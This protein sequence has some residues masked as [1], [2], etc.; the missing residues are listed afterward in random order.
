M[1]APNQ[2]IAQAAQTWRLI[3]IIVNLFVSLKY[4]MNNVVKYNDK[5]YLIIII[6]KISHNGNKNNNLMDSTSLAKM[7]KLKSKVFSTSLYYY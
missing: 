1:P 3:T 7:D 2:Y 4:R 6:N 5:I